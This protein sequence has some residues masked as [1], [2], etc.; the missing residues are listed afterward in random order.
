V[1]K[2]SIKKQAKH[3]KK[4][5]EK[6]MKYRARQRAAIFVRLPVAPA[7]SCN[8]IPGSPLAPQLM[9]SFS[10]ANRPATKNTATVVGNNA[11]HCFFLPPSSIFSFC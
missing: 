11:I 8:A 10:H 5:E 4:N 3:N 1:T 7:A 2:E 6:E 9:A